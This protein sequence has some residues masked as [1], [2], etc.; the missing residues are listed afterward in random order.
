M[1]FFTVQKDILT[2]NVN[3]SLY[4]DLPFLWSNN[5]M[6]EWFSAARATHKGI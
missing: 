4:D 5:G 3:L 6:A 2:A 1:L